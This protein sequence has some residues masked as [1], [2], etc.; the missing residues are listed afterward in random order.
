MEILRRR[1]II[2]IIPNSSSNH[3]RKNR[4]FRDHKPPYLGNKFSQIVPNR[5]SHNPSIRDQYEGI[6][7]DKNQAPAVYYE[8][9]RANDR[10][11]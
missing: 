11:C 3:R 4:N 7:P 9:I 1:K 6:F 8:N 10:A 2:Q 5:M